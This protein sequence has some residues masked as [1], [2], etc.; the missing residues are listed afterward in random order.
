[1][2]EHMPLVYPFC[3]EYTILCTCVSLAYLS[4]LLSIVLD[5]QELCC[6]AFGKGK[7]GIALS[8]VRCTGREASLFDCSHNDLEVFTCDHSGDQGI[9]CQSGYMI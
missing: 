8:S 2:H 4:C 3:I 6:A 1:M 5:A 9:I 7:G